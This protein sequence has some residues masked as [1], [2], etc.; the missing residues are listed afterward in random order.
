MTELEQFASQLEHIRNV[1]FFEGCNSCPFY[2][3]EDI[4]YSIQ[5]GNEP[6]TNYCDSVPIHCKFWALMNLVR[7]CDAYEKQKE[8]EKNV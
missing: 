4:S 1:Y 8:R 3:M 2:S 5:D 6:D 7:A